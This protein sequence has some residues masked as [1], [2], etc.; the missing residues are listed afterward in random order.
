MYQE[1]LKAELPRRIQEY[2]DTHPESRVENI[3]SGILSDIFVEWQAEVRFGKAASHEGIRP[4]DSIAGDS[5]NAAESEPMLTAQG[6]GPESV[7]GS[8]RRETQSDLGLD[9]RAPRRGPMD[10]WNLETVHEV[11]EDLVSATG[12]WD[13]G[14]SHLELGKSLDMD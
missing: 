6:F 3:I 8:D 7:A 13:D 10:T 12:G 1:F 4:G 11:S 2:V 5:S 9:Y 14:K